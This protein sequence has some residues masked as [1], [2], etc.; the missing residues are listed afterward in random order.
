MKLV[1][2]CIFLS[3]SFGVSYF[4][5]TIICGCWLHAGSTATHWDMSILVMERFGWTRFPVMAQKQTLRSV[6]ARAGAI[7]IVT[8]VRTSR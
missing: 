6:R 5:L 7:T 4:L 2:F 3:G 8:T 1:T